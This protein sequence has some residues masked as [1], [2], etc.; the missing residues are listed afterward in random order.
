MTTKLQLIIIIIIIMCKFFGAST[1]I[2]LLVVEVFIS[3]KIINKNTH[4]RA[5]T[6]THTV[7]LL[8]ASD[9]P[10]AEAATCTTY[11]EHKGRTYMPSNPRSQQSSG[12]RATPQTVGYW[13]RHV[14][15]KVRC[16][17]GSK[18]WK[19]EIDWTCGWSG[20]SDVATFG[21]AVYWKERAILE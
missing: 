13:D 19:A 16:N 15:L 17:Y 18:L 8:W 6:H 11:K 4:A 1:Q 14:R 5:R 2:G 20:D 12:S 9:Q 10:V 7:G 21:G 3:H